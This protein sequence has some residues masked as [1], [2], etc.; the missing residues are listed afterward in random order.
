MRLLPLFILLCLYTP[1]PSQPLILPE[2]PADRLEI[3]LASR[4]QAEGPI[5]RTFLAE[6]VYACALSRSDSSRV[7]ESIDALK[8]VCSRYPD[9]VRWLNGGLP[10][11]VTGAGLQGLFGSGVGLQAQ[12]DS[13]L[14]SRIDARG[15]SQVVRSPA[16]DSGLLALNIDIPPDFDLA[17]IP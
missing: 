7:P 3:I 16:P 6:V 8:T 5:F 17:R 14:N 15:L 4:T 11:A 9:L 12:I 10:S 13:L 2:Y 1:T